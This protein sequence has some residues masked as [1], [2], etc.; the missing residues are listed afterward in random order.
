MDQGY[1]A[2][3]IDEIRSKITDT[4]THLGP[5]SEAAEWLEKMRV[6]CREFLDA[7]A[8]TRT[9]PDPDPDLEPALQQLREMFRSVAEHVS[10]VYRLPSAAALV[11]EMDAFDRLAAE[12][13]AGTIKAGGAVAGDQGRIFPS[14]DPG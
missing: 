13:E 7:I 4:L 3:S 14:G 12:F 6:A 5:D 8:G 11:E 1:I 10:A 2:L 9:S